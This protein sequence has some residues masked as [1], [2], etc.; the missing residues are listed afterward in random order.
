MRLGQAV[1]ACGR[2]FTQED[3]DRHPGHA[4]SALVLQAKEHEAAARRIGDILSLLGARQ[5]P[6][7]R[8]SSTRARE[9]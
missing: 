4:L 9:A 2:Y 1:L 5:A 8:S 3:V 7:D 6:A